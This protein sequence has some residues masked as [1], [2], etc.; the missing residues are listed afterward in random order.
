MF[1]GASPPIWIRRH[2]IFSHL[3]SISV[4]SPQRRPARI[5][6]WPPTRMG[7][8][9]SLRVALSNEDDTSGRFHSA[10]ASSPSD[11]ALDDDGWGFGVWA[12]TTTIIPIFHYH[13]LPKTPITKSSTPSA[14]R[15]ANYL[16]ESNKKI[17]PSST[18]PVRIQTSKH[19]AARQQCKSCPV[20]PSQ[21]SKNTYSL[22]CSRLFWPLA[23]RNTPPPHPSPPPYIPLLNS[24]GGITIS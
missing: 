23:P 12:K 4:R 7:N 16:V 6:R 22:L 19:S 20:H 10:E 3:R 2:S 11:G 13:Q 9:R 15:K 1:W 17:T 5:S 24:R 21:S 8:P 18:S 14:K